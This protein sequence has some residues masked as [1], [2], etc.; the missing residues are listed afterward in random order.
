MNEVCE[1]M[2]FQFQQK[3][4]ELKLVISNNVPYRIFCD[5]K[6][7]K[8]VLFNILGN[9]VKFTFKGFVKVSIDFDL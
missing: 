4:I 7:F 3:Q 2:N 6:R 1:I 5:L 8:Q 9:A